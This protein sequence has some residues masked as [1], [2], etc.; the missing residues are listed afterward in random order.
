[1][2]GR[3]EVEAWIS[4]YVRAWRSPGTKA[5]ATLFDQR[6]TYRMSPFAPVV[7]GLE[8]IAEM[9]EAE[10]Q[11]PDEAFEVAYEPVAV[12]G[13]VAVVR[14]EVEYGSGAS[15]RDL[16]VIRFGADG[17]CTAFEE[18][19]YWPGQPLAAEDA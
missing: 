15:Y 13:D 12:D 10:R 11:G 9:W 18:W 19:P 16:W 7:S 5:L 6:A 1:M 4:G 17:L 8:W 3:A 14:V 2:T